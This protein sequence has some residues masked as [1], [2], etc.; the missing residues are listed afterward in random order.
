MYFLYHTQLLIQG[1]WRWHL[2]GVFKA[3]HF[4]LFWRYGFSFINTEYEYIA[5]HRD[6][7]ETELKQVGRFFFLFM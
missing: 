3:F 6:I 4:I 2:Q 5:L 1:G 7:G